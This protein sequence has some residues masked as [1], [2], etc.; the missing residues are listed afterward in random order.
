MPLM[1]YS[2]K[3]IFWYDPRAAKRLKVKGGNEPVEHAALDAGNGLP[4][5]PFRA[6]RRKGGRGRPIFA[7]L[8]AALLPP[9][10]SLRSR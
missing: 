6:A 8:L 7:A 3:G 2:V 5:D 4:G 1:E 9:D 10:E